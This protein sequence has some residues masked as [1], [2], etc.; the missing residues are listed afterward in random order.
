[1]ASPLNA[2]IVFLICAIFF[3][4]SGCTHESAVIPTQQVPLPSLPAANN[5]PIAFIDVVIIPQ[6]TLAAQKS[7]PLMFVDERFRSDGNSWVFMPSA[8]II[9]AGTLLPLSL[10][11]A[12]IAVK[13]YPTLEAAKLDGAR[14]ALICVQRQAF[15]EFPDSRPFFIDPNTGR[16]FWGEIHSVEAKATVDLLVFEV[17]LD[18]FDIAWKETVQG[19]FTD[20]VALP[21]PLY[22]QAE[23]TADV[24]SGN[25]QPQIQ[26]L[27][28]VLVRAYYEAA[29]ALIGLLGQHAEA[30]SQ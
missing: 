1:M 6:K 2:N 11:S 20:H 25:I 22:N 17:A 21:L 24:A 19:V 12:G 18:S 9:Q 5:A 4:V 7:F 13:S 23:F 3:T 26:P 30:R 10:R 27:R 14:S 8:R 28:T 16:G 29:R 15:V